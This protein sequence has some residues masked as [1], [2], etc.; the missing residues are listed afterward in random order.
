MGEM[1][2]DGS[3]DGNEQRNEGEEE[4]VQVVTH[5]DSKQA[6]KPRAAKVRLL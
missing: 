6:A 3:I 4:R 1:S 5:V 2:S